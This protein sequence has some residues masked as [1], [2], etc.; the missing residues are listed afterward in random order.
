MQGTHRNT[1]QPQY[2]AAGF[3]TRQVG[4]TYQVIASGL[5]QVMTLAIL[6]V[7]AWLVMHN[8]GLTVGCWWP[9]KCSP[10]A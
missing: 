10:A 2:L 7:G 1:P 9:S 5:E 6:I 8:S 3:A 4:N